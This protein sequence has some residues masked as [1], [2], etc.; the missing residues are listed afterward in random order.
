MRH[1]V[2][3]RSRAPI[4]GNTCMLCFCLTRESVAS[5]CMDRGG[6]GRTSEGANKCLHLLQ[7]GCMTCPDL[8]RNSDVGWEHPRV[9]L[10]S[11]LHRSL[12]PM[13]P[14]CAAGVAI[15]TD[16]NYCKAG[17]VPRLPD[18]LW[19]C[20]RCTFCKGASYVVHFRFTCMSSVA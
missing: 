18:C 2:Y 5:D 10:I 12:P 3:R 9:R 7:C 19:T 11:R 20:N 13:S 14:P 4:G 17:I 6:Q 8:D 15:H 1:A 16:R